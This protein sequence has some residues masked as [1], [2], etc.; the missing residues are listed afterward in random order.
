MI[1][2]TPTTKPRLGEY[3]LAKGLISPEALHASLEEQRI[4][5]ERLGLILT[6]LGVLTRSALIDAILATNADAIHAESF[7]TARVPAQVLMDTK[8]MVV[9][10]AHGKVY[11]AT[12]GSEAQTHAEVSPYYPESE[13][14]FVAANYEQVD[15]Y[16]EDLRS[17][18]NDDDSLVDKLLRRAFTE[19][20]SD[21][22]IIPRYNSYSVFFR[23]L[24]HRRHS[25][26]GTL[27]EYNSLAARIKDLSKMD[28]AERRIPQDGAFPMEF[29]GKMA[30]VRV[31]TVVTTNGEYIVIR[32]LDPDRV[33]PSLNGLGITNVEEWRRAVSRSH[34][35]CLICGPTGSGKTTTLNAS[36]KE[37]D[38]FGS[39]I[40][41]MEDPV[42]YRI[43]FI[44]QVNKN[45]ALG[46]DFARGIRN[47]MRAD[48][49]VIVIGEI[50]DVET[51]RNAVKA[52]ET[53][54]LVVGTL[55]TGDILGTVQRLRD[56][57]I[58]A[59]ELLSMLRG[60]LV[61]GLIRTLCSHCHGDGCAACS[62]TGF[63]GRTVVSEC[64]YLNDEED[65]KRLLAGERWW[66]TML[67]DALIKCN[68][69]L[70]TKKEVIRVFGEPAI[71]A[72]AAQEA[73]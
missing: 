32:L 17:M 23:N 8:T 58:P 47:F 6:R 66:P 52:S 14:V 10:E 56:L 51:A 31:A 24:G 71:R 9:A 29:N 72:F 33:Q 43:P 48:P 42:E 60:I 63:S 28:L 15:N 22:H 49:D 55:H 61:Q 70:T 38:R 26:E 50:R 4:T 69:G 27:D 1:S 20:A 3:L 21:I 73:A 53:G 68:Q 18:Q 19:G 46:L 37:M 34:G 11:L 7:F 5:H 39:A 54:H 41:T 30:D 2:P 45:E 16:L 35:L 25:H 12:L 64:V 44:G 59:H 62:N 65:V 67:D 57:E 36:L 40:F 13:V